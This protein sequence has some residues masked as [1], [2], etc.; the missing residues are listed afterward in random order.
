MSARFRDDHGRDADVVDDGLR[1]LD[2]VQLHH[3]VHH[4]KHCTIHDGDKPSGYVHDGDDGDA[5]VHIRCDVDALHNEHGCFDGDGY[6][7]EHHDL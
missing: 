6:R 1:L 7:D 3:D 2:N 5:Y 4:D